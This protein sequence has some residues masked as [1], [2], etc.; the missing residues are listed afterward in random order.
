MIKLVLSITFTPWCR[1]SN[2]YRPQVLEADRTRAVHSTLQVVVIN[3]TVKLFYLV[4][5]KNFLSPSLPILYSKTWSITSDSPVSSDNTHKY[6]K[7]KKL[8]HNK[9]TTAN[10]T[11]GTE[12][13]DWMFGN[14]KLGRLKMEKQK[15]KWESERNQA[16]HT[17]LQLHTPLLWLR[18]EK[19]M[20]NK[21]KMCLWLWLPDV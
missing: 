15:W 14:R 20:R 17:T 12:K 4:Y 9:Y 2:G 7:I 10:I 13:F 11:T 16:D 1:V 19:K 3:T 5:Y 18:T 6:T 21:R 8:L